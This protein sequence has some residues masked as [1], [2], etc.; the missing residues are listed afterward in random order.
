MKLSDKDLL[1]YLSKEYPYYPQYEIDLAR[2]LLVLRK[3]VSSAKGLSFGV[4][5]NKGTA[6]SYHRQPLLDAIKEWEALDGESE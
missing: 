4:D 2:E 6:A 5:W 1:E 3:M